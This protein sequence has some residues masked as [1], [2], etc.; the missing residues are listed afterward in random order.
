MTDPGE[1]LVDVVDE[2]DE[3]VG[4]VSRREMRARNLLHRCTYVFVLNTAEELYVHRR[5]E[6]KDVYPGFFDVC[7]G[8]V[9]AAGESY[10]ACA[11]RELEEEL[12]VR[13][14]PTFRFEHR[15]SAPSGQ[16]WGRVFDVVWDGPVVWQ[17]EEVAWGAFLPLAEVDAMIA[18]ERF[19]P[20]GLEVFGRWR[21]A[22]YHR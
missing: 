13:A 4:S 11:A 6:T 9:N 2:A 5:T 12:G 1:E 20:D 14:T 8:G 10:E 22:R 19:C 3:V 15:Y 21:H 16:A 18:R 17:P 7:A